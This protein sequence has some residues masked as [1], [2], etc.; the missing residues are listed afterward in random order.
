MLRCASRRVCYQ[1]FGSVPRS[2]PLARTCIICEYLW[3]DTGP[4]ST[5]SPR[6]VDE[7]KLWHQRLR[8]RVTR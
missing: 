7:T 4:S 2:W 1:V 6:A 3:R 8:R 5:R